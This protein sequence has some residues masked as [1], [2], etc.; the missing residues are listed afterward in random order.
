MAISVSTVIL[1]KRNLG[2]DEQLTQKTIS[3]LLDCVAKI[4]PTG[5]QNSFASRSHAHYMS[6]EKGTQQ[7]RSLT[8]AFLKPIKE[9]D[10]LNDSIS[11]FEGQKNNLNKVYG[12]CYGSDKKI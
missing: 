11:S 5:K 4:S 6:V 2:D 12:A 9:K 8:V 1:L 3:S 7:P 10:L